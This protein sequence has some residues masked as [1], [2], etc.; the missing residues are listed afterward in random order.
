MCDVDDDDAGCYDN[1][2]QSLQNASRVVRR[3][4]LRHPTPAHSLPQV[5]RAL[6]SCS[7]SLNNTDLGRRGMWSP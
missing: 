7:C 3:G 6:L 4:I 1:R 2:Q 5:A